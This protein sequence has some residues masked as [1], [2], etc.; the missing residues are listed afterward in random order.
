MLRTYLIFYLSF[1]YSKQENT[2]L[3]G[4]LPLRSADLFRQ[5]VFCFLQPTQARAK[6]LV[7]VHCPMNNSIATGV[8]SA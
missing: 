7:Q 4:T 8:G 6:L 3:S 5:S 2:G 1:G